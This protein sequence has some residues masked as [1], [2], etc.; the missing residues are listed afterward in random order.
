MRILFTAIFLL[1]C[2]L[3]AFSQSETS[4]WFLNSNRISVSP[5]GISN[6]PPVVYTSSNPFNPGIAST[7][8]SDAAGNLLFACDGK[9]IIDKNLNVMPALNGKAFN[10]NNDKVLAAK[11]PN[12]SKYY[13]FYSSINIYTRNSPWTLK[14]AIVDLS[15]NGG[16]GDV[17]QYDQIVASDVSQGFTLAQGPNTQDIWL[18]T[19]KNETT[20]FLTYKITAA[21][22]TTTPVISN[23]SSKL[24]GTEYIFKELKTSHNGKMIAGILYKDYT[25]DFAVAYHYMEVFNFDAS[26][27]KLNS[28]VRTTRY[29]DYYYFSQTLE[30]SAD[31]RLL[32]E[33]R[34]QRID[35]L[36]PCGWG[37]GNIQQYNLCYTDS[38]E[39]TKYSMRIASDFNFC[40]PMSSW[41]RIQIGADKK[42]YMPHS[43]INISGIT[44]PNR[45]GSSCNYMFDVYQL[46]QPNYSNIA[47]PSFHHKEM[48]KAVK[49][50]IIYKGG[51]FPN[52]ITFNITNDTITN[53]AW[54]FGDPS[55]TGNILNEVSPQ[56]IFSAAGKYTVKAQLY[57]SQNQLI[58]N[59]SEVIEVKD[60][61]ERLLSAYPKDTIF[62]NGNS[63][64]VKLSAVNSIFYWTA[65]GEYSSY[66]IGTYDS[67][68][69]TSTGTYYVEMRQNDCDGCIIKDSIKVIVLP[70]P[71]VK[72]GSDRDLC[73]GD[74]IQLAFYDSN[75][76]YLWSTGD[77]TS[78]I[79][80]KQPGTYWVKA[81]YNKNG[82]PQRDTIII[83][84]VP[85]VTFALPNDTT[86]CNNQTLLLSPG[87]SNA[88]YYWQNNTTQTTLLVDKP[89]TYWARVSNNKGCVKKD[90]IQVSYINAEQVSLGKDTTLCTGE[91]LLLSSNVSNATYLWSTWTTGNTI[92]VNQSGK[93][94]LKVDNGSCTVSDTISVVFNT[95]PK[96]WLGN[97][98]A[99]CDK[100]KL[101]LRSSIAADSYTW[102]SGIK[103]D[104]AVVTLAGKYWLEIKKDGCIVSDTIQVNYKPLPTF[105]LGKDTTICNND[106]IV[107]NAANP[108]IQSYSWQDNSTQPFLSVARG[109]N[110]WVKVKGENGC[111]NADTILVTAK[112]LPGFNLGNDTAL[113]EGKAIDYNISLPGATYLWNDG[114][115][116]P[117]YTISNPGLYWLQVDNGCIKRDSITISYKPLP[118]INL[119]K[120]TILCEGISRS[121]NATYQNA[122]YQWQDNSSSP[123]FIVTTPGLY[124][125]T[126]KVDGCQK[127]D[128]IQIGYRYKPKFS[129]GKD[130]TL[131]LG[132]QLVLNPQ[133]NNASYLWQNGSGA[134]FYTVKEVGKYSVTIT[135]ECGSTSD[136]IV[137]AQGVCK[138]Y[139]PTAFTPDNDGL[140]DLFRV[141]DAGFIET[142]KMA[143]YNRWGEIVFVTNDPYK[144]WNGK[145]QNLDQPMG[146]YVWQISL[147][148]KDGL[149]DT[150][151][152]SVILIR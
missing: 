119:G 149:A 10:S 9:I 88:N 85:G 152:G 56:H 71:Y 94:W 99:L 113:C 144:G 19:H 100:Q 135:N 82:C 27:G 5:S 32:Y 128:S 77:A 133:V 17:V 7:S 87:V 93:Y 37:G 33:G 84:E 123:S 97:D 126:V 23:A 143:I 55:G 18:I 30:F 47:T 2:L 141:K 129:L 124:Y 25:G 70:S 120:D 118:Q 104:S 78:S 151:V 38:I 63:L 20:N 14:Y 43:G 138:L 44:N 29:F 148:T 89:G 110:Y 52:P 41:G 136:E 108:S 142:F 40:A 106:L 101:V 112:S 62:C 117:K 11:I 31:D 66:P 122:T 140:N 102:Q 39:F 116:N 65:K 64:K 3:P 121:L 58:E 45:I 131:C 115:T 127:R 57:N 68:E 90:T 107:L 13:V 111:S 35:G 132:E 103:T 60:P 8:V 67:I 109:G 21:G 146:N 125:A 42:I 114:T 28:R 145:Y 105:G 59:V 4:Q 150:R 95:P 98:T 139:M 51:C 76:E 46:P 91:N 53:I 22:I 74:S 134:T 48:E 16:L 1:G 26:S 24:D 96:L 6:L 130:T 86:L 81:E 61:F 72:L 69:I 75:A 54:D 34:M 12:S 83:T 92:I 80:V 79:S 36:Q 50:N 137:I 73:T 15:L 49:N 147:T